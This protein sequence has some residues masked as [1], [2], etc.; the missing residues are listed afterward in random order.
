MTPSPPLFT[1]PVLIS[2]QNDSKHPDGLLKHF[3]ALVDSV[4]VAQ[5]SALYNGTREFLLRRRP[6]RDEILDDELR[7][8]EICIYHAIKV[9]VDD[10]D[11]ERK[12]QMC[13]CTGNQHWRG[14]ESRNDWVWVRQRPGPVYGALQGR[15]PCQLLRLF[16][17]R[18]QDDD[19]YWVD[20]WMTFARKTIA[21]NSGKLDPV[22]QF[23]QVKA[24]S[25]SGATY[26]VFTV[27]NVVGCPH[28]IPEKPFTD[29]NKNER[30][31]VNS[32]IDL[33]TWNKV[34]I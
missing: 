34:Y 28:V 33:M 21:E 1:K 7:R 20:H 18:F 5:S 30:W 22:S 6:K 17:M 32:H 16:K 10:Y 19:G 15:L 31:I 2:P 26:Q 29:P 27:G 11:G 14:G 3:G 23:A 12:T 24:P 9:E 8:A 25:T 4:D 13:R